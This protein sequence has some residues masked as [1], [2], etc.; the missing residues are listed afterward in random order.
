MLQE[1]KA[2]AE[3]E[4][5]SLL[6]R[7]EDKNVITGKWVFKVKQKEEVKIDEYKARYVAKGYV[8]VEGIDFKDMFAAQTCRRETFRT[9]LAIAASKKS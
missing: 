4:T 3:I 5:W 2:F 1:T 6:E 7:P 9:V 8:Q